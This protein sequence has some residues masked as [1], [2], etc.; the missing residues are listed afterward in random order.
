MANMN[1]PP[2]P[3]K[4][5]P[6]ALLNPVETVAS[7]QDSQIAFVIPKKN[8]DAQFLE[9][10]KQKGIDLNDLD[11]FEQCSR[12]FLIQ[13]ELLRVY[14]IIRSGAVNAKSFP[15]SIASLGNQLKLKEFYSCFANATFDIE[16]VSPNE[17]LTNSNGQLKPANKIHSKVM[18]L[19]SKH[20][21]HQYVK[22]R[23]TSSSPT[24]LDTPPSKASVPA[25]R[26]SNP[27][28]PQQE[29]DPNTLI[30]RNWLDIPKEAH[31]NF[32]RI[33]NPNYVEP[34]DPPAE[35]AEP[36][37]PPVSQFLE[38]DAAFVFDLEFPAAVR[39]SFL[40]EQLA[41][42]VSVFP[43]TFA[44]RSNMS[45][46]TEFERI[47]NPYF[48]DRA[49]AC[50]VLQRPVKVIQPFKVTFDALMVGIGCIVSAVVEN[51]AKISAYSQRLQLDD[52]QLTVIDQV[53]E[54]TLKKLDQLYSMQDHFKVAIQKEDLPVQLAVGDQ[55]AFSILIDPVISSASNALDF[56]QSL[57]GRVTIAWSMQ[58]IDGGIISTYDLPLPMS[59]PTPKDVFLSVKSESP[60]AVNRVFTTHLTI[61][62]LGDQTKDLTLISS[63]VSKM[64]EAN[65]GHTDEETLPT[66]KTPLEVSQDLARDQPPIICLQKSIYIGTLKPRSTVSTNVKFIALREGL[67]NLDNLVLHDGTADKTYVMKNTP[68]IYVQNV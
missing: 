9:N 8:T 47:L 48:I 29:V 34:T 20:S 31:P 66:H 42:R 64:R 53:K 63:T 22:K 25:S 50:R 26:K 67:Y 68:Q 4:G 33:R 15:N 43:S 61:T 1:T 57:S 17:P 46:M 35:G 11:Q 39:D 65:T 51:S 59:P 21:T 37:G 41:F 5:V 49:N 12:D 14:V 30:R 23:P 54:V 38:S 27:P 60:V 16:F 6:A 13:G 32:Y 10:A 45:E 36:A 24:S 55:Y 52:C 2:T 44:Y 3:S 40:G 18:E 19:R 28:K 7:F 58:C 62:N 56:P